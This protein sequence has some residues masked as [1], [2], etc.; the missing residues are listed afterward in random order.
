MKKVGFIGLGLMGGPMAVNI[1]RRGFPLIVYNRSTSKTVPL[2]ELGAAVA[3]S[4][5]QVAEASDVVVT[6]LS[7]ANAVEQVV[8]PEDGLVSGAQPGMVF[9]DMSTIAP[10]ESRR[11][12]T[13]LAEHQIKMLD[14]PV[15]GSTGPAADGTLGI[16]VG[17]DEAIFETH[18]DVLSAMGTGLYYMG[19]QG[20]GA[21][22]KLSINLLAAAQL[23]S[24][25][26][27]LVMA[28]KGGLDLPLAGEIVASSG[29]AS[30]LISRK[31][32]N[33]VN[34]DYQPAFPLKHMQ[35]DLGLMASTAN[36][37]G[38][39]I[40]VTALI[41]QLFTAAKESG[42]ADDDAIALYYLLAEMAGLEI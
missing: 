34:R 35:K 31:V 13:R 12:A 16:M 22:M 18:R 8:F 42:H 7:D 19:P 41:H 30:N 10:E 23:A 20:S 24:L 37:I 40:P 26:E 39:P 29:I 33:I 32:N 9:I 14:A 17:G 2:E 38:V 1:A 6:M 36:A 3:S 15:M 27:A 25:C 21:Q 5:R 11:I 4:P 28:V